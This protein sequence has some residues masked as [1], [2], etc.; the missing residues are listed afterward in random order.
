MQGCF[1]IQTGDDFWVL[2][3]IYIIR[4]NYYMQRSWEALGTSGGGLGRS[5]RADTESTTSN[6]AILSILAVLPLFLDGHLLIN[7]LTQVTLQIELG[8]F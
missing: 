8:Q 3:I 4:N 1:E 7:I 2:G 5:Q 6:C